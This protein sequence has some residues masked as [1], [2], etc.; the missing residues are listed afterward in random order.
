MASLSLQL[1]RCGILS[2]ES[3]PIVEMSSIESAENSTPQESSTIPSNI[4]SDFSTNENIFTTPD[5]KTYV[6]EGFTIGGM[7]LKGLPYT[8]INECQTG[9]KTVYTACENSTEK[10]GVLDE[11]LQSI[12]PFEYNE[13]DVKKESVFAASKDSGWGYITIENDVILP[14]DYAWTGDID[15]GVGIVHLES[16]EAWETDSRDSRFGDIYL[17]KSA[18]FDISNKVFISKDTAFHFSQEVSLESEKSNRF[19]YL[20]D[21]SVNVN[22]GQMWGHSYLQ[23]NNEFNNEW[24]EFPSDYTVN[25]VLDSVNNN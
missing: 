25:V 7:S 3:N 22:I 6:I 18:R 12:I 24:R 1:E 13:I 11:N 9:G 20:N 17:I 8:K 4:S 2:T 14:F 10:T 19:V 16:I 23:D 5:G 15:N 21:H